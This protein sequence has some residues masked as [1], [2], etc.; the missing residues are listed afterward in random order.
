MAGC[1][2]K[3]KSLDQFI[4]HLVVMNTTNLILAPKKKPHKT[5]NKKKNT[6]IIMSKK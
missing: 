1:G 2:G 3:N 5:V 4:S 6:L